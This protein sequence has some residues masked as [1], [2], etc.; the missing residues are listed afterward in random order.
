MAGK[1]VGRF[2][3]GALLA[4]T[5]LIAGAQPASAAPPDGPPADSVTP[6]PAG[7][8][9][10]FA[11]LLESTDSNTHTKTFKDGK[12]ISAGRGAVLT[13]TNQ[14]TGKSLTINSN[15]SVS[16]TTPNGDD[17]NT[18]QATGHNVIILFPTDQPPGPSTILYV[19][20]VVYT[21]ADGTFTVQSTSGKQTDI[22]AQLA[23]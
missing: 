11:L 12:I 1:I 18:V 4:S 8:A 14:S 10:S 22:C 7:L 5:V 13:F 9:C 15:G 20:R 19:G 6:L 16:K 23:T 21:D 17:T 2:A 3:A